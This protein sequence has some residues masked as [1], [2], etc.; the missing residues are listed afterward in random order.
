MHTFLRRFDWYHRKRE[1]TTLSCLCTVQT[2]ITHAITTY[3]KTCLQ[4]RKS[5]SD[6]KQPNLGLRQLCL[7]RTSNRCL[8]CPVGSGRTHE[9]YGKWFN[10]WL[11]SSSSS[12]SSSAVRG[13]T[14]IVILLLCVAS[15]IA[16]LPTFELYGHFGWSH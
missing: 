8:I 14:M 2:S 5:T 13:Y 10:F 15:T 1:A 16:F 9:H 3:V 7:F 6:E 12:S 11:I 4:M